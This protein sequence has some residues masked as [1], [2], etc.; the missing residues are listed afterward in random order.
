LAAGLG[1][2]VAA[3]CVS[4]DNPPGGGNG[5]SGGT[6]GDGTGG[7]NASGGRSGSGGVSG[8]QSGGQSGSNATGGGSGGNQGNNGGSQGNQGGSQGNQGG[9]QGNQGGSQGNQGGS[10]PGATG[11]SGP[12]GTGGAGPTDAG[13]GGDAAAS[14][15]SFFVVSMKALQTL[16]GK[17]EGFGGDLRFGKADG[18]AGADEICRRAAD[19]AVPGAG[20][21]NWRALLSASKGADGQPVHA[22]DR[23]GKGPWYDRNGALLARTLT[24]LFSAARPPATPALAN[25][26]TNERGEPNH[27]VGAAGYTPGRAVDNHDTLTGS[28]AMGMWS[29]D[30]CNDWTTTT[31]GGRPM[32]GHSWPRS[33]TSGRHW[34]SDHSVPGC[35]PGLDRTLGGS[36]AGGCV[37]CSGGYGGF[38]CF[39]AD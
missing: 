30:T 11:G 29:G 37:G 5:S 26:R 21:K 16:S 33:A 10:G 27:Y 12:S 36:G 13:G 22:R 28:N 3:G 23:I 39:V 38:F 6:S 17:T 20:A 31:G 19:M 1:G 24:E 34:V 15:F 4:T 8:G 35:A 18:L 25:D 7:S 14:N 2:L 9:S 32:I